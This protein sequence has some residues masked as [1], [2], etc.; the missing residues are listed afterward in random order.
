M[1]RSP[2]RGDRRTDPRGRARRRREWCLSRAAARHPC[3]S[4]RSDRSHG[5]AHCR[6][7]RP[8]GMRRVSASSQGRSQHRHRPGIH[9]VDGSRG[10]RESGLPASPASRRCAVG[11]HVR[12]RRHRVIGRSL[13]R[14]VELPQGTACS[15][16]CWARQGSSGLHAA[17]AGGDERCRLRQC[18]AG[19]SRRHPCPNS[20]GRHRHG[21]RR[22]GRQRRRDEIAGGSRG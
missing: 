13:V 5:A 22:L 12:H 8:G 6:S 14:S 2:R 4:S 17:D 19:A 10:Q 11:G 7:A 9:A 21:D 18:A 15:R 3:R 16:R 20:Q 1:V